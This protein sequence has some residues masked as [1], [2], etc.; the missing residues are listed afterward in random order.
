M[1]YTTPEAILLHGFDHPQEHLIFDWRKFQYYA[2]VEDELNHAVNLEHNPELYPKIYGVKCRINDKLDVVLLKN[3]KN[4]GVVW[5]F[6]FNFNMWAPA[7][8]EDHI[9]SMKLLTPNTFPEGCAESLTLAYP[10]NQI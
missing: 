3:P 4:R 7:E 10:G 6:P 5:F 9:Y 1:G 8:D 2:P